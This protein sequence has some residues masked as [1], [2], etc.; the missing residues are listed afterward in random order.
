MYNYGL[1][2]KAMYWNNCVY[3]KGDGIMSNMYVSIL[4]AVMLGILQITAVSCEY[5]QE[6]FLEFCTGSI[7]V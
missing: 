6:L 2:Y 3:Y 5:L 1:I 7:F 4:P